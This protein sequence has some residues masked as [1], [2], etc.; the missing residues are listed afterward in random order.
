MAKR[1]AAEAAA[2]KGSLKPKR[3]KQKRD[4]RNSRASQSNVNTGEESQMFNDFFNGT[5]NTPPSPFQ[6]VLEAL[7]AIDA[8]CYHYFYQV[9]LLPGGEMYPG[10]GTF[11]T[12]FHLDE[13]KAFEVLC[14]SNLVLVDRNKK[15]S[16]NTKQWETIKQYIPKFTWVKDKG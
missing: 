7:T 11:S 8:H 14:N 13:R 2:G 5:C 3:K 6:I 15:A 16:F 10:I 12:L 4:T 1:K 9:C